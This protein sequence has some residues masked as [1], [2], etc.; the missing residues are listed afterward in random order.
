[1]MMII[2]MYHD[3]SRNMCIEVTNYLLFLFQVK[4]T[5]HTSSWWDHHE[6]WKDMRYD[7]LPSWDEVPK[8]LHEKAGREHLESLQVR[9]LSPIS[10]ITL[11]LFIAEEGCN[12][13]L[14]K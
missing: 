11:C 9:N 5:F 2:A 1:M 12:S 3:I 14:G 8:H 7:W 4:K 6:T 10:H 13:F